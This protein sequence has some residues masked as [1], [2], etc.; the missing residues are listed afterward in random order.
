MAALILALVL[1][2]GRASWY[3]GHP[4][5]AA[6]GPALRGPGWRGST[7]LVLALPFRIFSP[8]F[9]FVRL[10]DFCGCYR[11]TSSERAIDLDREDFAR[12]ADPS[13]GLVRVAIFGP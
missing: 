1:A 9:V 13:R 5:E 8:R 10:T 4:G 3:D 11:G 6:A 12:L 7:V 2:T